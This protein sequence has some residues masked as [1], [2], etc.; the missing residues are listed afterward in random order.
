MALAAWCAAREAVTLVDLDFVNPYFRS[1]DH[2]EALHALGVQVI[3][4]EERVAQ[5]DAPAMPP[6]ARQAMVH[7]TGRTIVDLG[8]DPAGAIVIGQYAADLVHYDLWAVVN[9]ARPTTATPAQAAP[10]LRDIAAATRLHFTGLV[11]NTH[12]GEYT[13]PDDIRDGLAHAQELGQ[14]LQVPV[15][16]A[17]V[18]AGVPAPS[19]PLPV[20]E[21]AP[22]LRKP[23]ER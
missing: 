7:P 13:T 10:L 15:V 11:S 17:T 18:P 5:I 1:Q 8:G 14:L 23:W 9:F 19:L 22:R 4:P 12:F 6:S 3:A 2:Q 21:I 16:L 20:L